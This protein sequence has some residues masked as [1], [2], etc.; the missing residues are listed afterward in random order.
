MPDDAEAVARLLGCPVRAPATWTGVE[1]PHT[2]L[3][4]PL[5]RRDPILRQVLEGHAS[6]VTSPASAVSDD[7]LV[8]SLRVAVATRMATRIPTMTEIA[9]QLA[10]APRTLQR[11]LA[12]VGMSYDALVDQL[13][14]ESAERLL[15]DASLSVSEIGYLLGFSEPSAF[16]RAFKRW[17]S[18]TP[19]SY[20]QTFNPDTQ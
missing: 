16:H 4:V 10:V 19:Q 13:R 20:R 12:S 2:M 8:A 5:R 7:S 1:F 15:A 17:H 18:C 14:R 6:A 3:D 9:R 11:R